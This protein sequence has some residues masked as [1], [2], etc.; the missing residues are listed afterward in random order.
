VLVLISHHC[1]VL[2]FLD[3]D[4]ITKFTTSFLGT[5]LQWQASRFLSPEV[6]EGCIGEIYQGSNGSEGRIDLPDDC[7]TSSEQHDTQML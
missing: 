7:I 4:C 3:S 2:V 6:S 1:Q 5:W